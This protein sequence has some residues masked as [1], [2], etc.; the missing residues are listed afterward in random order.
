MKLITFVTAGFLLII[1]L[2]VAYGNEENGIAH[3]VAALEEMTVLQQI[4]IDE[5]SAD[6]ASIQSR[7]SANFVV[8]DSDDPPKPV[9][10]VILIWNYLD[11]MVMIEDKP[12]LARVDKSG[13][14][15]IYQVLFTERNCQG[16]AHMHWDYFDSDRLIPRPILVYGDSSGESVHMYNP[17]PTQ[18]S[19]KTFTVWSYRE[20][21][22][23]CYTY[24]GSWDANNR[25]AWLKWD[26]YDLHEMYPP[27]YTAVL[28]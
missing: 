9:G 25:R 22:G 23:Y 27:P 15:P 7:L 19:P 12:V 13:F 14:L 1:P 16:I 8:M 28:K 6:I 21:K 10:E 11:V 17:D 26:E 3:R 20:P 5:N 18:L 24:S 4:E 2:T